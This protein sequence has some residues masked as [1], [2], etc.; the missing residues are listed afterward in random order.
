M[1]RIPIVILI[2]AICI[3]LFLLFDK[4][5]DSTEPLTS[6]KTITDKVE[7]QVILLNHQY[8][9]SFTAMQ[10]QSDSLQKE[11]GKA[12][13]QLIVAKIK[14]QQAQTNIVNLISKDTSGL[15]IQQK[16][17]DCDSIKNNIKEYIYW[18]DSTKQKYDVTIIELTNLLAV[19]DSQLVICSVYSN[20][21]K[22]N[23]DGNIERERKL[24]KDLETAYKQN[25]KK[26]IQSKAWAVGFLILSG[27]SA[28]LLIQSK[29]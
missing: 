27:V 6:D 19:K 3:G 18:I 16:L 17:N 4:C 28:T 25:R 20:Q 13:K 24:T 29:Q 9:Q 10:T 14:L 5:S 11:L 8:E 23:L 1:K 22:S 12:Q 7:E 2:T 26:Q 21:L 15:S